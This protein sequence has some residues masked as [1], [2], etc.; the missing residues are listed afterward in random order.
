MADVRWLGLATAV[1]QVDTFT[2]ENVEIG[3]IFT[4]T[5]TGIDGSTFAVSFTATATTV[6]NVTAGITSAWNLT[7]N[8]LTNPM[9]AVDNTTDVTLT[10]DTA[11]VAFSVASTAV[12]G[13]ATD[14]QTFTR[15]AT[16]ASSGPLHWD[17]AANWST[18]IVPGNAASQDVFIEDFATDILYGLDQSGIANTL[19]S[20]NFGATFT[21]KLGPNGATGVAGDYLQIK[22]TT[23]NIGQHFGSGTPL[24]SGRIKIDLGATASTVNIFRTASPFDT[25]KPS[26]RLKAAS[27]STNVTVHRGSVGIAFESGETST[28]GTVGVRWVATRS[29][30]SDVFIGDGVTITTL[31]QTAGTC[32]LRAAV[33]T[34][35]ITG[36]TFSTAGVGAITTLN[37]SGG[38]VT[39]T[40]TAAAT[41]GTA[42]VTGGSVFFN[43]L[44]TITALNISGG[45]VDFTRSTSARTVTTPKLDA[46]GQ[47]R[48]DPNDI[49]MTNKIDSNNPVVLTAA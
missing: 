9:T 17:T 20:L 28:V 34:A 7:D 25:T 39:T 2:P 4:L 8:A 1:A 46:G 22:A 6:A 32:L 49:T 45:T 11:G 37:V 35:T 42:N 23:L 5:A 10:A 12:N 27:A 48:Y 36:G 3:D 38:T 15:G 18:G 29:T 43:S 16:T 21:G 44:G 41:I 33:T 30:D 19:A 26:V 24:G 40:G 13:G 47:L 14:D 31:E